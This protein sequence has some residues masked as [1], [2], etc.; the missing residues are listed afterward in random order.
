MKLG[1]FVLCF[2][3]IF[4]A[5]GQNTQDQ[6]RSDYEKMHQDLLKSLRG[7]HPDI[8]SRLEQMMKRFESMDD[9]IFRD[10]E[11][12]FEQQGSL[13]DQF[14]QGG[15]LRRLL[16]EG[17]VFGN[18]DQGDFEW[19]ETPN[20]RVLVANLQ[21]SEGAPLDIEIK[22]G[23]ITFK[24]E[25]RIEDI[26]ESAFGTSRSVRVQRFNRS[27]AIPS[28]VDADKAQFENE[29]GKILVTFPKIEVGLPSNEGR[30]PLNPGVI[31]GE[32]KS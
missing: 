18:L 21:L 14:F 28:D 26:T 16:E 3:W 27:F 15:G 8:E 4:Q 9:S 25:S 6:E 22:N 1:I 13:L 2:L 31:P 7:G 30:R 24:G 32:R 10:M 11:S 19:L 23:Q 29:D 12:M 20:S 5:H 17:G